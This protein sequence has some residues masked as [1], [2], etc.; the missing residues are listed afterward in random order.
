MFLQEQ[1]TL[2]SKIMA[3]PNH[4][5]LNLGLPPHFRPNLWV[6]DHAMQTGEHVASSGPQQW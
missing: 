1:K 5:N 6:V 3:A 2:Y 4:L